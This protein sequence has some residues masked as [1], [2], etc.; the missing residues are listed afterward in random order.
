M[1]GWDD[2][3]GVPWAPYTGPFPKRQF[4]EVWS[5]HR[6]IDPI[7]VTADGACASFV[8]GPDAV[9]FAGEHHLTDYHSPLGSITDDLIIRLG[10]TTSLPLELDS[11]PA[12]AAEPL[13]AACT[14]AGYSATVSADEDSC[15]VLDL[16]EAEEDGWEAILR[17]KD[18]HELRRKRRRYAEARGEPQVDTGRGHL[19]AF[20]GLH[21][22]SDGD[23]GRFMTDEMAEFFADLVGM[24]GGRLD[25]L[26]D[27]DRV[28]AA[29]VG[30]EDEDAYYLYNSAFDRSL[31]DLSPGIVLIDGLVARAVA[32]GRTRFDFL[33]GGE[34]YKRRLGAAERALYRI[35]A[36]R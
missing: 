34:V 6:G 36:V 24:A 23:K 33:K 32:A 9:R 8:V 5:Q 27:G 35:E 3:A 4:L 2:L 26:H 20:I 14:A 17:S 16:S 11:L 13:A 31:G 10:D 19:D 30:F 1:T 25:V 22:D 29:A 7:V 28:V 15:Q 12:E 21:R 18:R